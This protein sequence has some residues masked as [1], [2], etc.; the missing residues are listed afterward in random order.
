MELSRWGFKQEKGKFS[1]VRPAGHE[2][3]T[4]SLFYCNS[5]LFVRLTL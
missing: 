2:E 4:K 1:G 5:K 3:S